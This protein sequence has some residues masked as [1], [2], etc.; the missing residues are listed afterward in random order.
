[1][2]GK[3]TLFSEHVLVTV[4][5]F[6]GLNRLLEYYKIQYRSTLQEVVSKRDVKIS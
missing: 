6:Q 1:M 2:K 3:N 5:W 4:T